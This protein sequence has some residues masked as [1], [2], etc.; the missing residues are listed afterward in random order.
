MFDHIG[1]A[2]KLSPSCTCIALELPTEFR[3]LS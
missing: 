1:S 3:E 2:V